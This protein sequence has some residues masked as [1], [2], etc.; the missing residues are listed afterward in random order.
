LI[1]GNFPETTWR[2]TLSRQAA[3][4]K[5]G[6]FWA[7]T[8]DRLAVKP[9]TARRRKHISISGFSMMN[10]LAEMNV[11]QATQVCLAWF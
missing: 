6:C 2:T 3:H 5:I 9:Y 7:I 1:S 11:C 8:R 4:V 10:C